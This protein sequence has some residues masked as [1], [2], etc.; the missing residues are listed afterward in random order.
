M[1][2]TRVVL[3]YKDYAALPA[4]GKRYELHEG[5][6]SMTPAPGSRHQQV[7]RNL[8]VLL[9]RHVT[10]KRLGEV[11]YAPLDCILSDITVVQPDIVFLASDRRGLISPRGIEGPPTLVIEILSPSTTQID[12]TTKLQ[13]YA[14]YGVPYYWIVEPE[15]I[16]IEVYGVRGTA[17]EL[18]ARAAGPDPVSLFP[19]SDLVMSPGDFSP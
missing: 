3:T 8:F 7:S 18:L 17:Y 12:R 15:P 4:D 14:R 6:L 10:S 2:A 19:F 5:E 16:G 11:L 13:L 9:H 1:A